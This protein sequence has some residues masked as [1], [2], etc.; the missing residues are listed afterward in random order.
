MGINIFSLSS[1]VI[2]V[3]AFTTVQ[4]AVGG[5]PDIITD[6]TSPANGSA[7]NPD[8]FTFTGMR[9][10]LEEDPSPAFRVLKASMSEFPGLSGQSV[11][12]AVLEFPVGSVNPPHTHPRSAELL[13]LISGT[14]EVGFIDTANKLFTQTLQSG[15]LFVFPKG[16]VHY[17][18][19]VDPQAYSIAVSAFG[20]ANA[21]TVSVPSSV[22]ASG[23]PD[24]ILAKSFKTDVATIH[25]IKTG[26]APK[27]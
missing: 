16:L 11:S 24:G 27:P 2:L 22:F 26:L 4:I 14:L 6:F 18:Q 5:D 3:L 21:G 20:S 7:A 25:A 17:Q 23:I 19:N 1:L 9:V 10:L 12:Y 13:F 8:F 15:D